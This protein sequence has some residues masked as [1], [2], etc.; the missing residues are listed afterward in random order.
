M[1]F[2]LKFKTIETNSFSLV[3]TH[4]I[5]TQ[6]LQTWEKLLLFS[7]SSWFYYNSTSTTLTSAMLSLLR[8][9]KWTSVFVDKHINILKFSGVKVD[10]I[11]YCNNTNTICY[12]LETVH[13]ITTLRDLLVVLFSVEKLRYGKLFVEYVNLLA[14]ISIRDK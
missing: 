8:K 11:T 6:N 10:D 4:K 1:N 3:F 14:A 7:C 2:C 12:C 13:Y 5:W 9:L